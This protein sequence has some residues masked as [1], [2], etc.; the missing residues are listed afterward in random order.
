MLALMNPVLLDEDILKKWTVDQLD[1]LH[2]IAGLGDEWK[3]SERRDR[4]KKREDDE[5]AKL[6]KVVDSSLTVGD[7]ITDIV[8]NK[9]VDE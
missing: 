7:M 8:E 2:A 6:Q 5:I 3:A 9:V 4:L 1:M